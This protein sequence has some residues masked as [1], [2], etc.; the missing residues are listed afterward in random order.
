MFASLYPI[1]TTVPIVALS[2]LISVFS[3]VKRVLTAAVAVKVLTYFLI[4]PYSIGKR[5]CFSLAKLFAEVLIIILFIIM[6]NIR[7][8][9]NK[10]KEIEE[11]EIEKN[12]SN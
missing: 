3:L 9:K 5:N 11:N 6:I 8:K 10:R 7:N 2:I 1:S 12:N 4:A